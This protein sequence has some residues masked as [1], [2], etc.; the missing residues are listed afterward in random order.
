M[1]PR[2]KETPWVLALTLCSSISLCAQSD[3][4]WH[5]K[6]ARGVCILGGSSVEGLNQWSISGQEYTRVLTGIIQSAEDI[7]DTEKRLEILPGEV[8]VGDRSSLSATVKSACLPDNVPDPKAG[9][10]WLFFVS[11]KPYVDEITHYIVTRGLQ[12]PWE[13]SSKPVSQ[14]GEDIATLRRMDELT[15]HGILTGHVVRVGET[16]DNPT[17]LPNHKV[18]ARNLETGSEY[19]A[20]TDAKGRFEFELPLGHYEV[21]ASTEPGQ[22]ETQQ[23]FVENSVLLQYGLGGNAVVKQHDWTEINDFWLTANRKLAGKVTAAD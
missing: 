17:L 13:S 23:P 16:L 8:F 15:D 7:S 18:I 9:D 4:V 22:R 20:L 1:K 19:I 12:I 11:P 14:A 6:R 3:D 21:S 5:P 2:W 10:E